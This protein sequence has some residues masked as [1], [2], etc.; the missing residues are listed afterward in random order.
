MRYEIVD[1]RGKTARLADLAVGLLEDDYPLVT[2]IRFLNQKRMHRLAWND[3]T[4]VDKDRRQIKVDDLAAADVIEDDRPGDVLMKRD[5]LD[6]LVID[7]FSRRTTR[8]TDLL[9]VAADG[10]MR[11]KAVDAGLRAMLRRLT[12]GLF[13]G[14]RKS[15]MYDWKYIEF[16]RGDPDAVDS[17]AGYR[18]RIGRLPAG[19]IAQIADYIPYL[20]AA[21]LLTLLPDEKAALVLQSMSLERQVQVIE[22][23]EEDEAVN[24]LALMSPDRATDLVGNLR[25]ETMKRYVG[26]IPKKQR[27]RIIELLRY[28]EDSVGGVMINNFVSFGAGTLVRSVREELR[29]HSKLSDFISVV[30]VTENSDSNILCGAVTLRELLDSDYEDRLK[31]VMDP[32]I[33]TLNPFEPALDAAHK[34]IGSRIAAMPVTKH[35]GHLIGA[36]LIDAAI[37]QV[38]PPGSGLRGFNVFS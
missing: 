18:L 12:G 28:P 11:L 19:E 5:I 33:A 29:K 10:K 26:L 2:D 9:I 27:E 15:D 4:E 13:G 35:D 21:E 8:A 24:L 6:A 34:L 3:T 14:F 37:G 32:Y 38:V 23:F 1:A 36:M 31:D 16:L 30:F 20:H 22:E 17:G 25:F 7:L